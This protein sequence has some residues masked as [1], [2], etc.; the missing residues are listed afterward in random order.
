[1]AERTQLRFGQ[2]LRLPARRYEKLEK[3]SSKMTINYCSKNV[4]IN[5]FIILIFFIIPFCFLFF[6][7]SKP[8]TVIFSLVL[9]LLGYSSVFIFI[10]S[11]VRNILKLPAIELTNEHYID[12]INGIKVSWKAISNIST[13][14]IGQWTFI[15][16][17]LNDYSIFF[18]QIRNPIQNLFFRLEKIATGSP[19]KTNI[20]LVKGKNEEIFW[21]VFNFYIQKK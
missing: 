1:M 18:K 8:A 4:G 17:E 5:F 14:S 20:S 10:K 19:M 16:F 3:T 11:F 9:I 12:H 21:K 6:N 15:N 7:F 13:S 2:R